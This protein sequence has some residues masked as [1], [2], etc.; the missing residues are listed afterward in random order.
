MML[1]MTASTILFRWRRKEEVGVK[2]NE[3]EY[4]EE[5]GRDVI[6]LDVIMTNT[7]I[8]HIIHIISQFNL[9]SSAFSISFHYSTYLSSIFSLSFH[10]STYFSS[11]FSKSFHYS[12]YFSSVFPISF[13]Y[14][15]YVSSIFFISFHY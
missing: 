12:T 13:H 4:E 7:E 14:S 3:E 1:H 8:F 2:E 11:V 9:F 5:G 6:S 15:T 10:S